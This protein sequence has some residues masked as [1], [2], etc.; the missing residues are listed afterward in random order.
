MYTIFKLFGRYLY[1]KNSDKISKELFELMLFCKKTVFNSSQLF[2]IISI[3]LYFSKYIYFCL[4][5]IIFVMMITI[6]LKIKYEIYE[7]K[8]IYFYLEDIVYTSFIY[9][10]YLMEFK[11]YSYKTSM[12]FDIFFVMINLVFVIT[13][14]IKMNTP[15]KRG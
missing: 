2:I 4:L 14:L 9:L 3:C 8:K 11:N 1:L 6:Y 7:E 10:I 5:L 15:A 13:S 12:I